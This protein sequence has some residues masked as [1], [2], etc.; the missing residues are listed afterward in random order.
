MMKSLVLEIEED[1][2]EKLRLRASSAGMDEKQFLLAVVEEHLKDSSER[3]SIPSTPQLLR[4]LRSLSK[5]HF[6]KGNITSE[7]TKEYL[8]YLINSDIQRTRKEIRDRR[9]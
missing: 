9:R 6:T 1:R 8:L 2:L 7:S 3:I 5:Y 4:I